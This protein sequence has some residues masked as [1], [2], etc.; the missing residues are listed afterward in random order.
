VKTILKYHLFIAV[1]LLS[2]CKDRYAPPVLANSVNFLVVDGFLN[3][4][5]DSTFIRLSHTRELDSSLLNS[6][7]NNAQMTIED[8]RGNTLYNFREIGSNGSYTLPGINL[9][10]NTKYR[11]RIKTVSGKEY[12]SDEITVK[13]TPPIDS[14]NWIKDDK[15]V[16]IY[17]NAHDISGIT[18]YYRWEYIET[19][20][21]RSTLISRLKY[22]ITAP[23]H[24][25]GR[26][27]SEFIYTCWKT[28]NTP[29][30]LLATSENL[31]AD[32]ISQNPIRFISNNSV[33][34]SVKYS[35]LLKQYSLTKEAYTY[36]Q[37]L[38]KFT[39]LTGSIF[40][41][42]PLEITGN[43]HAINNNNEPVLGYVTACNMDTM[44]IYITND[45]VA[46]WIFNPSCTKFLVPRNTDSVDSYFSSGAY[47]PVEYLNSSPISPIWGTLNECADCRALGGTTTKPNFWP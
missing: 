16:T 43:I 30:L 44:R 29:G 3:N 31:S 38:R 34:L 41:A 9:D 24:I 21:Y 42:Q 5:A 39:E 14:I 11:L 32:I 26:P 17:S 13:Q 22:D 36:L 47:I 23:Y 1:I 25:G 19:Y 40:D 28:N 18:K 8:D 35:I 12:L 20:Q 4:S 45:E 6:G 27:D 10:V 7:E 46:P 15:G 2:D 37:N 33:E